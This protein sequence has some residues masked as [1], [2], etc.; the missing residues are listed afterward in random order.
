MYWKNPP[1][2]PQNDIYIYSFS[3]FHQFI[4]FINNFSFRTG[5]GYVEKME[6]INLVTYLSNKSYEEKAEV[7]NFLLA[8]KNI[9]CII[10]N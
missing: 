4:R 5:Y 3:L 10:K 7:Y 9:W 1:K 6:N 2:S 8:E